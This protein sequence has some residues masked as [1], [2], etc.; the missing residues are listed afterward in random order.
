VLCHKLERWDR[1]GSRRENPEAD[2]NCC[3]AEINT[4]LLHSYLAITTF[5]FLKSRFWF[6]CRAFWRLTVDMF[7]FYLSLLALG[8]CCCLGFLLLWSAGATL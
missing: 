7:L 5:F 3:N 4:T 2:S 6:S 8:L 1:V